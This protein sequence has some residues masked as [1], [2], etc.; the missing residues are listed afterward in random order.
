MH[1]R[2]RI[3]LPDGATVDVPGTYEGIIDMAT[4]R[5][6]EQAGMSLSLF[7]AEAK[8]K[9]DKGASVCLS[10]YLFAPRSRS[11]SLPLSRWVCA[12]CVLLCSEVGFGLQR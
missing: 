7:F 1:N 3:E 5:G 11:R 2:Y 10:A 8:E 6:G 9:Y 12:F 4:A